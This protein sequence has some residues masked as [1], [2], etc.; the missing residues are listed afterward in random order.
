VALLLKLTIWR[1]ERGLRRMLRARGIKP[2]VWSF[3]AYYI[4]P[5]HMVFVVGVPTDDEKHAL[6]NDTQFKADMRDLLDQY[7]WPEHARKFVI[8]DI[9]SDE[10]VRRETGGNWWYHY[11]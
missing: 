9:E 7:R 11:K 3:G 6:L 8:F 4:D 10:T 2:L 1:I 5:K